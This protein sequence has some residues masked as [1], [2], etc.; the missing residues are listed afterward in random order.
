[1]RF[2]KMNR[3][4]TFRL[5]LL[6]AAACDYDHHHQSVIYIYIEALHDRLLTAGV[7]LHCRVVETLS[8]DHNTTW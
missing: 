5:V 3:H 7:Q 8:D 4:H 2:Y 6:V 1:M